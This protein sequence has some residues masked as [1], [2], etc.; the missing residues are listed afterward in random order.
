MLND[1]TA[2]VT[3]APLV[4]NTNCLDQTVGAVFGPQ[5]LR[6]LWQKN[7]DC[8]TLSKAGTFYLLVFHLITSLLSS[9]NEL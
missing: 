6:D 3:D 5:R 2:F 7:G 9:P 8:Q 4:L 1:F